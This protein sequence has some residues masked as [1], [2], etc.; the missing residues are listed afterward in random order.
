[1][2]IRQKLFGGYALM[3]LVATAVGVSGGLLN[4][5]LEERFT[6]LT[7]HTYLEVR[8][9][10]EAGEKAQDLAPLIERLVA[11]TDQRHAAGKSPTDS[12]ERQRL[13]GSL[14]DGFAN[15]RRALAV[16]RR[17]TE[18][19]MGADAEGEGSE[20]Q[21]LDRLV[22]SV[23]HL[24]AD[25]K[26]LAAPRRPS[27]ELLPHIRGELKD[28]VLAPIRDLEDD[29]EGEMTDAVLGA[30][31][32]ALW[33]FQV[34]VVVMILALGAAVLLAVA[35]GRAIFNPIARLHAAALR[36]SAGD[37]THRSQSIHAMRWRCSAK[38]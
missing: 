27:D 20:L 28:H 9:A 29:A 6:H 30:K 38:P 31:R 11:R 21:I 22:A 33:A 35:V 14:T 32:A 25:V 23:A 1:M 3:A 16:A 34:E 18:V 37:W 36:I 10:N 8:T 26:L 5:S 4:R 2:T 24:E 19:A 7:E 15:L 17:P 13:H 12:D